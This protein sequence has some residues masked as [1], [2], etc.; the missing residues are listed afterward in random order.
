MSITFHPLIFGVP[1]FSKLVAPV[2]ERRS[3]L[4][5]HCYCLISFGG[6]VSPKT[7]IIPLPATLIFVSPGV[8]R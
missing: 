7:E 5:A 8:G 1:I 4:T 2:V 6:S 3:L